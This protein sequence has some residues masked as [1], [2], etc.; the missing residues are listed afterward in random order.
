M[1]INEPTGRPD[2]RTT[3]TH[4]RMPAPS[5]WPMVLA[6]GIGFVLAGLITH[7][8]VTIVGAIIALRA[9][10]GWWREVIPAEVLEEAPIDLAHRPAPIE[11]ETRSVVRLRAGEEHHR[12]AVPETI[13][14]Y[15]A[16]VLGGIV[17]G[18]VM[19]ALACL[20][21]LIAE[22]S[23]WY[24]INLLAG[25]VMPGLGHETTEQLRLFNLTAFLLALAGHAVISVLVGIIYAAILPMF[26]KYAPIWA[27]IL[28]P[29]FWSGV[30]ATTLDVV[31]PALNARIS[32]PWFIACQLGYGLVGGFVIA[33]STN[34]DTMR[35]LDFASRAFVHAPGLRP[36]HKKGSD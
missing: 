17:G 24:P 9:A 28:M 34:I 27:G 33:R 12:A 21:G 19:A 23:I 15:S 18:A 29:V 11:A 1:M 7:F 4:I 5:Y 14:P 30:I 3:Q 10:V 36:P 31:N 22:H 26:P 32:W 20:Y 16:G 35:S 13:H 2:E 6:F 8:I 25:V